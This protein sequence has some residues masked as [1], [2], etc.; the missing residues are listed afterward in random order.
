MGSMSFTPSS[1]PP[2]GKIGV[3][4]LRGYIGTLTG[5]TYATSGD[6]IANSPLAE[7]KHV[8][9]LDGFCDDGSLYA[10]WVDSTSKVM[11]F[12]A[13]A[14]EEANGVDESARSWKVLLLGY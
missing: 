13:F 3:A 2:S 8:I 12:D 7:I 1:F 11:I 9:F 14:T 4:G 5:G 6:T 10:V